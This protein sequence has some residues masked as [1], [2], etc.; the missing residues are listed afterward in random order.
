MARA[1]WKGSISFG[2][3]NI[4]VA[5]FSAEN[6]SEELSFHMLDQRDMSPVGYK[7]INK[8]TGDDV[9]WDEI[10]KGYEYEDGSY[11]VVTDEDF[12]RANVEATRTVEIVDFVEGKQIDPAYY[13][14]PYYLAPANKAANKGYALLRETLKRTG[15]VGIAKVVIR[16]REY[17]AALIS[18]GP[19]M[20][21]DVMRYG[22]EVREAS[23]VE[24]P[25]ED[26]KKLGVTDKE[27]QLAETLVDHMVTEW[28]PSKYKDTYREDVLALIRKKVEAGE[29]RVVEEAPHREEEPVAGVV[30]IM[31]L[32]KKSV[33]ERG[34]PAPAARGRKAAGGGS[35]GKGRGQRKTA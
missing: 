33:A 21:L 19:V 13:E 29:T 23:E 16:T 15:K 1:I 26:L 6:R 12:I 5:L 32:L 9:P 34:K 8:R 7:R 18:H 25:S 27:L 10:V 20:L 14:K 17:V 11:V 30:D 22:Y 35:G 3:V 24:V 28:D 2:L 31:S 4:P